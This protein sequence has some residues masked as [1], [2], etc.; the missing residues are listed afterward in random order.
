M[1]PRLTKTRGDTAE[2]DLVPRIWMSVDVEP[3]ITEHL[4]GSFRGLEEGLPRLLALLDRLAAPSDFFILGEVAE[5]YPDLV[6]DLASR[7]HTVG[8]HGQRHEYLC[9]GSPL[10][11]EEVIRRSVGAV[12]HVTGSRIIHFR[13]PNFSAN[14]T[15]V[16]ALE[17]AGI[18]YDSS[19]L[20]GRFKKKWRFRT[21]YDHRKA[22][23]RPYRPSVLD[24]TKAD[25]SGLWEVPVTENPFQKGTPIGLGFLNSGSIEQ[26]V[27]AVA[28]SEGMYAAFL[29][30]PWEL[31]DLPVREQ[32]LPRWL[33]AAC[34]SD[35][36]RLEGFLRLVSEKWGFTTATEITSELRER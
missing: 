23:R 10:E 5:K 1:A 30:H 9:T 25:G 32:G 17:N 2:A 21:V 4:R 6:R 18:R 19:V 20:P 27:S 33:E 26:T 14:G 35:L 8:S 15:T 3:D 16:R 24:I 34:R 36:T 13:A 7:G 28:N 31:V 12:E 22:P 11:Q 29:V